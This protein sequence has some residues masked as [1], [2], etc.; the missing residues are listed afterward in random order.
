VELIQYVFE[1]GEIPT[2]TAWSVLVLIPKGS[3]GHRGIGLL[4][5][6]WKMISSIIDRYLKYKIEF[7]DDLHRF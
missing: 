3:G 4:E 6:V 5:I 2:E 1:K 7:H